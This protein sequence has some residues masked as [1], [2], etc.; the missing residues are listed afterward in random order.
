MTEQELFEEPMFSLENHG[1]SVRVISILEKH[2]IVY[3]GDLR[4]KTDKDL[5]RLNYISEVS[6]AELKAALRSFLEKWEDEGRKIKE[7]SSEV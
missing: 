5:R 2:G 7:H 3:L 6:I 4:N 1:L